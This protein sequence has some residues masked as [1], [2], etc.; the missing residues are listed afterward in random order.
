MQSPFRPKCADDGILSARIAKPRQNPLP[1]SSVFAP[2]CSFLSGSRLSSPS[3]SLSD[4]SA[5][6]GYSTQPGPSRITLAGPSRI[7]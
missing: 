5:A 6:A 4:R 3:G 1:G 2:D 7:T